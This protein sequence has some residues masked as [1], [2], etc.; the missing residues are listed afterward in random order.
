MTSTIEYLAN[1]KYLKDFSTSGL[2]FPPKQP[3]PQ[4][5]FH[6]TSP[7]PINET[8]FTASA[9]KTSPENATPENATPEQTKK[10]YRSLSRVDQLEYLV[11]IKIE[12]FREHVRVHVPLYTRQWY[13]DEEEDRRR[14]KFFEK[15]GEEAYLA[16][17]IDS[18]YTGHVEFL[19]V[20]PNEV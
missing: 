1:A 17:Y 12:T 11:K 13:I 3:S 19:Y 14:R 6:G 2:I 5:S 16:R 10:W 15:N 7:S 4:S 8:Q 18:E 20:D 9:Q